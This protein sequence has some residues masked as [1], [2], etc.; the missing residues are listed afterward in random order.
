[1]F[2]SDISKL[3]EIYDWYETQ[4]SYDV[5]YKWKYAD[6]PS[7]KDSQKKI[8]KNIAKASSLAKKLILAKNTDV[9]SLLE[10][11]DRNLAFFHISWARRF[12]RFVSK[13]FVEKE[14]EFF[15]LLES[16]YEQNP[17]CCLDLIACAVDVRNGERQFSKDFINKCF[18]MVDKIIN[19]FAE[20]DTVLVATAYGINFIWRDDESEKRKAYEHLYDL[21]ISNSTALSTE[22]I[23]WVRLIFSEAK[24]RSNNHTETLIDVLQECLENMP[25]AD[26]LKHLFPNIVQ[27]AQLIDNEGAEI[28]N[29]EKVVL[30]SIDLKDQDTLLLVFK[31]HVALYLQKNRSE[32]FKS[33][34]YNRIKQMYSEIIKYGASKALNAFSDMGEQVGIRC[35]DERDIRLFSLLP[36]FLKDYCEAEGAD[37][38]MKHSFSIKHGHGRPI[39][40]KEYIEIV[41]DF[42][43]QKLKTNK[44]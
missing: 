17:K 39:H 29:F 12:G 18:D 14:N 15:S 25:D 2:S 26:I 23:R 35:R 13:G 16:V 3:R 42:V 30:S 4:D 37:R 27:T 7:E 36:D 19:E 33:A 6:R 9:Y 20:T 41:E 40:H 11:A 1:M 31:A 10:D 43:G 38:L 21:A 28:S 32:E 22:V 24:E 8:K 5:F 44:A 34:V